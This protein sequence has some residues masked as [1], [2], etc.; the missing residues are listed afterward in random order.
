M[1]VIQAIH[2]Q[3]STNNQQFNAPACDI[4]MWQIFMMGTWE[5]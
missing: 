4:D 1:H 2:C 5:L 3:L